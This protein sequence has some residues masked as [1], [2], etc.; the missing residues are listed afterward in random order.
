MPP[1]LV[2][3]AVQHRQGLVFPGFCPLIRLP[4]D[5]VI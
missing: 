3:Q 1:F 2:F 4:V 5:G